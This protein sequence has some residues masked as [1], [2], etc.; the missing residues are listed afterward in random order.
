MPR[1]VLVQALTALR[2]PQA[3]AMLVQSTYTPA[4]STSVHAATPEPPFIV[5]EALPQAIPVPSSRR[6]KP[7]LV[8]TALHRS[9]FAVL[10]VTSRD[11]RKRIVELAEDGSL[12]LDHE[13]DRK[14]VV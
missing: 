14:S 2:D 7:R 12:E 9:P 1:E 3:L 5:P 11:D 13:V 6:P 10:G 4:S 8:T